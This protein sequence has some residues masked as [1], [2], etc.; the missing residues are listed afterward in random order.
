MDD[1]AAH[2]IV[3]VRDLCNAAHLGG[4]AVE[5]TTSTNWTITGVPE[6]RP[7]GDEGEEVDHTGVAG[8]LVGGQDIPADEVAAVRVVRP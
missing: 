4:I 5:I 7:A 6:A 3:M 2:Y 8:F 1:R